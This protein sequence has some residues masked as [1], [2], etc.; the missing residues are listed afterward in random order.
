MKI[1]PRE[2]QFS[3]LLDKH[4]IAWQFPCKRFKLRATTY[5]PDFY[6]PEKDIYIEVVGSRQ[7][8]HLNKY[9]F[10]EFLKL[11]PTI[12]F[13]IADWKG[14]NYKNYFY[15]ERIKSYYYFCFRE[16]CQLK[17]IKLEQSN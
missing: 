16:H 2:K 10:V 6:L 3:K 7:A 15:C 17:Y 11:Y 13:K 9:K 12:K 8:F 5:R 1:F 4:N 14:R